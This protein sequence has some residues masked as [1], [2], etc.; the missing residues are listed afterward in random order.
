MINVSWTYNYDK[1]GT[2]FDNDEG[3]F[4]LS[5]VVGES[6]ELPHL[7][8]RY[9][10][11]TEVVQDGEGLTVTLDVNGTA[12]TVTSGKEPVVARVASSYSVAGDVV[13]QDITLIITVD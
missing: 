12:Y 2:W 10:K 3:V 7:M 6:L 9:I 8:K 4:T 11:V 1:E 5:A 13:Y